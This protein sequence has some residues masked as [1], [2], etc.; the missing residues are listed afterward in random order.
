[1]G[2][3]GCV[4]AFSPKEA[5][6]RRCSLTSS[7]HIIILIL[8]RQLENSLEG[9]ELIVDLFYLLIFILIL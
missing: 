5:K 1:L 3:I 6:A 9:L 7:V 4:F 2:G 8:W